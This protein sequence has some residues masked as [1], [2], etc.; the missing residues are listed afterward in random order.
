[1]YVNRPKGRLPPSPLLLCN[2]GGGQSSVGG[3]GRR[4]RE[5]QSPLR[6]LRLNTHLSQDLLQSELKPYALFTFTHNIYI[7][8]VFLTYYLD[9]KDFCYIPIFLPLY[10]SDIPLP[11]PSY[12]SFP[13]SLSLI[14]LILSIGILFPT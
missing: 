10:L 2:V 4:S 3:R 5:I 1:M 14:Q 9:V 8:S 11:S 13:L 12:L 7:F 6:K